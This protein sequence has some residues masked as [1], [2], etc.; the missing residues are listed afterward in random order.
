[1]ALTVSLV[2]GCATPLPSATQTLGTL[3]TP[4]VAATDAPTAAPA[5]S[6]IGPRPTP[7]ENVFGSDW[8]TVE[9]G[10]DAT[11]PRGAIY[12]DAGPVI[13]GATCVGPGDDPDCTAAAWRQAAAGTWRPAKVADA[14]GATIFDVAYSGNYVALGSRVEDGGTL[15]RAIIWESRDGAEWTVRGSVE[16]GDC[17][18]EGPVCGH[19]EALTVTRDGLIL[20]GDVYAAGSD[21]YHG[22]LRSADGKD[23]AEVPPSTFGD[24][25]AYIAAAM[26]IGAGV[27][28]LVGGSGIPM[29]AWRTTDATTWTQIGTLSDEIQSIGSL[30]GTEAMLVAAEGVSAPEG[31]R[32]TMWTSTRGSP[33]QLAATVDD[34]ILTTVADTGPNGFL[35]VGHDEGRPQVIASPDGST[36]YRVAP[37][38]P[39]VECA[40][41]ALAG[42]RSAALY[43]GSCG[44]W[45]TG[46]P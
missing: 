15:V 41:W 44:V 12:G 8:R 14:G 18:G 21:P 27:V 17:S 23:W 38:L 30:A 32:T 2:A 39:Q 46:R 20:I 11:D 7:R 43:V 5:A 9:L 24:P 25:G 34:V 42:A 1:L 13:V 26:P 16:I 3:A 36:W 35:A 45:A 6:T 22:A 29:T 19:A 31:F 33:F 4:P 10:G 40:P 37:G 28:A